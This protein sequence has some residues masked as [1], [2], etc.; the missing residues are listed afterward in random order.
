MTT[1]D[2]NGEA[3]AIDEKKLREKAKAY[4]DYQNMMYF[5]SMA[6][7]EKLHRKSSVEVDVDP[8]LME[9]PW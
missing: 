2:G 7:K 4:E 3:T 8:T 6:Q 9:R 1:T 5:K